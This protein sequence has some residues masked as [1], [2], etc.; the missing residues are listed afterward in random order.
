MTDQILPLVDKKKC[1]VCGLCVDACPEGVF[2]IQD[3]A[4]QF[5]NP[6]TCTYCGVC[7]EICPEDAVRL[8]Y[9]IRWAKEGDQ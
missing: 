3:G 6:Q 7:E 5:E 9:V 2:E 8:E 4:L 1:I